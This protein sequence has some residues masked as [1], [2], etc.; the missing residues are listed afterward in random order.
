MV[1]VTRAE[2][3]SS[4]WLMCV[5]G[6]AV[7]EVRPIPTVDQRE[8]VR[9]TDRSV[10][11][12]GD[13]ACVPNGF[14]VSMSMLMK[15]K[16]VVQLQP[17]S[18]PSA[19]LTCTSTSICSFTS[20]TRRCPQQGFNLSPI[21]VDNFVT[22]R[23]RGPTCSDATSSG[24]YCRTKLTPATPQHGTPVAT[25]MMKEAMAIAYTFSASF[26][27]AQPFFEDLSSSLP[28]FHQPFF[29]LL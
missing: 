22:G 5:A 3:S 29:F 28:P 2:C 14:G 24:S 15:A 4:P 19:D 11:G 10:H 23:C 18:T 7:V 16:R 21:F 8:G 20:S 17:H 27:Q 12:A 1:S 25:F 26:T 6:W 13:G 9:G